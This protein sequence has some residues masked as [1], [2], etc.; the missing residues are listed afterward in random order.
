M[1]KHSNDWSIWIDRREVMNWAINGCVPIPSDVGIESFY[2]EHDEGL[3]SYCISSAGLLLVGFVTPWT[4]NIF[5]YGMDGSCG[6]NFSLHIWHTTLWGALALGIG[7][8]VEFHDCPILNRWTM[9]N[10]DWYVCVF[11]FSS[12][13][14]LWVQACCKSHM[15]LQRWV[16]RKGIPWFIPHHSTV[17]PCVWSSSFIQLHL[18]GTRFDS[19]VLPLPLLLLLQRPTAEFV[20]IQCRFRVCS[21]GGQASILASEM[22]M[23]YKHLI[24]IRCC[25][26]FCFYFQY[27]TTIELW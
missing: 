27:Q 15:L 26:A 1:S 11:L 3:F 21:I 6:L 20:G 12:Q 8:H 9:V 19:Q 10:Q 13:I 4:F 7:I 22:G 17:S 16:A 23:Q 25:V 18:Q 5:R 24:M 2:S 14:K